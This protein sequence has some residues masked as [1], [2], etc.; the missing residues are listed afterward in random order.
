MNALGPIDE[1]AMWIR[2]G[3][4]VP[5]A[6][7]EMALQGRGMTLGSQPPSIFPGTVGSWLEGPWAGRRAVGGRLETAVAGLGAV[8]PD[9]GWYSSLPAPRSAAGPGLNHLFLG[10]GGRCGLI[11]YAW[12]KAGLL[13]GRLASV[14]LEGATASLCRILFQALLEGTAPLEV[15]WTLGDPATVVLSFDVGTG[16]RLVAVERFLARARAAGCRGR[17]EGGGRPAGG[18]GEG[19]ER[20]LAGGEWQEILGG[21]PVGSWVRFYRVA[22]ESVVAVGELPPSGGAR[23]PPELLSRI[24]SVL[25]RST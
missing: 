16:D 2:C 3:A 18:A 11:R 25:A 12:L 8:V 17:L 14:V 9:G 21:L 19:E 22:R 24:A 5:V 15:Q 23:E 20:E 6:Q 13:A 1:G 10:G 7:V 4:Q